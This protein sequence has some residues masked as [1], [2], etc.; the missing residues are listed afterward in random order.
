VSAVVDTGVFSAPLVARCRA[1]TSLEDQYRR[2]PIGQRL[3]IA[4]Q[5]LAQPD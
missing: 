5:T 4:T 2:H 1:G 3:V